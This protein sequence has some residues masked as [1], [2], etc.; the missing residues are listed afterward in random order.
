MESRVNVMKM[1]NSQIE[2]GDVA[3]PENLDDINQDNQF[4]AQ[5]ISKE[6]FESIWNKSE[7]Y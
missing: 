5:Y 4:Y 7:Y 3:F 1:V 6:E 2:L